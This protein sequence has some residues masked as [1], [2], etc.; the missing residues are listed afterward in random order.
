MCHRGDYIAGKSENHRL[1]LKI[2]KTFWTTTLKASFFYRSRGIV[3]FFL[4]TAYKTK[5]YF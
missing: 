2:K 1:S 3:K 5:F 4:G